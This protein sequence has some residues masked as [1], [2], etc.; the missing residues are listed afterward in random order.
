MYKFSEI[1]FEIDNKT[2]FDKKNKN[3]NESIGEIGFQNTANIYSISDSSK[4]GGDIGWIEETKLSKNILSIIS[5]LNVGEH[6]RPIQIGSDYL[7]LKI[8]ETK[9]EKKTTNESEELKKR[10]QFD[11]SKQLDRF[12]KIYYD[13]VKINSTINEL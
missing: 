3:I 10:I 11:T 9:L 4:F 1:V 6:S 8:E 5:K 2:D 13:K 12:S 7:I